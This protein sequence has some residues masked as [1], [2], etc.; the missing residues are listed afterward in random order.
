VR[1][2]GA[3]APEALAVL[4]VRATCAG[5]NSA[6]ALSIYTGPY[7]PKQILYADY[8]A[9]GR[10][11]ARVERFIT[12]VLPFYANTHTETSGARCPGL[13]FTS[14]HPWLCAALR[15]VH[16]LAH[17]GTAAA[18]N[19]DPRRAPRLRRTAHPLATPACPQTAA[20]T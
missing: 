4:R 6:L 8:A 19:S 14:Y 20:A 16:P 13:S 11:L 2:A 12:S 1:G 10:P 5:W 7:G 18:M 9:S 15:A 3:Y 17:S